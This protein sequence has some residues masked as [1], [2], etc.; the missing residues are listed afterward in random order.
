MA[1]PRGGKDFSS[2]HQCGVT[3]GG[4]A[5]SAALPRQRAGGLREPLGRM[6][7]AEGSLCPAVGRQPL[8][9]RWLLLRPRKYPA[10]KAAPGAVLQGQGEVWGWSL[11]APPHGQRRAGPLRA[12]AGSA[13]TPSRV[14]RSLSDGRSRQLPGLR[15]RETLGWVF[16]LPLSWGTICL[17]WAPAYH[18]QSE[19]N[20]FLLRLLF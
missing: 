17:P 20:V 8:P 1:R 5:A 19:D 12:L 10:I 13:R 3:S 6:Y 14:F 11:Q 2:G 15:F 9:R 4:G 7:L 16:H 18:L